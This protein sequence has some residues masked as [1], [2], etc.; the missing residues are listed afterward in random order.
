MPQ[1]LLWGGSSQGFKKI[2]DRQS[3]KLG[4]RYEIWENGYN[5]CNWYGGELR[6]RQR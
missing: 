2:A 5:L 6:G 4:A 1:S 3:H